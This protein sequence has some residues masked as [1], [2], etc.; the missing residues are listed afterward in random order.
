MTLKTQISDTKKKK[1]CRNDTRTHVGSRQWTGKRKKNH[2]ELHYSMPE[3][4]QIS[5]SEYQNQK[6]G[7]G[8]KVKGMQIV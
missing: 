8:N 2:S 7:M 6:E 3:A 5:K 4:L 1:V